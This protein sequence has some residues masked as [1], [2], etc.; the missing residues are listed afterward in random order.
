MNKQVLDVC[1]GSRM[2]YFDKT[3]PRVLFCDIREEEFEKSHGKYTETVRVCPDVR[4]DFTALPFS[5]NEYQVVVFDPP[6]LLDAG[7]TGWQA[8]TYGKLQKGWQD[9]LQKGFNECFRVLR[10]GGVLIFKWAEVD[11]KV[12][13]ILNLT[14]QKPIFGHRSGKLNKTHW[15]C[16]V[17]QAPTDPLTP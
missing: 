13:E 11:I 16:F 9:M 5:D 6:H 10:P 8:K 7:S 3:D 12:S 2:F 4:C 1:C 17:K 15:I 14:D